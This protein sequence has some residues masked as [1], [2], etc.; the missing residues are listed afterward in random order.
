MVVSNG[1]C[2]AR[3]LKG[4]SNP[5]TNKPTGQ[6]EDAYKR[7]GVGWQFDF[8]SIVPVQMVPYIKEI[9]LRHKNDTNFYSFCLT[10]EMYLSS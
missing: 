1:V 6:R 5:R 10:T 8:E 9:Y 4:H 3:H 7:E 2:A